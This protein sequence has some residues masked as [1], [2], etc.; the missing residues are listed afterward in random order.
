MESHMFK[1]KNPEDNTSAPKSTLTTLFQKAKRGFD[2]GFQQ[3]TAGKDEAS[4]QPI[5]TN[6]TKNSGYGSTSLNQPKAINTQ[7]LPEYKP[8][9]PPPFRKG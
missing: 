3:S 4:S 1:S 8:P 9:E 7:Q 2:L 5:V 6:S